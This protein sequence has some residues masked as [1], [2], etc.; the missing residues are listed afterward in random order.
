M[1]TITHYITDSGKQFT[2]REDCLLWET[3]ENMM[4]S[5]TNYLDMMDESFTPESVIANWDHFLDWLQLEERSE[6]I[7]KLSFWKKHEEEVR[8][9][10]I[11]NQK[12]QAI[13]LHRS[14]TN[15]GLRESK[16]AIEE[17]IDNNP[18]IQLAIENYRKRNN[19]K[20]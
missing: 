15:E 3:R 4:T 11:N 2:K 19:F 14:I 6:T 13:K 17:Y 10:L 18:D 7:A 16:D 20:F 12:I 9:L 8:D 1:K 5:F